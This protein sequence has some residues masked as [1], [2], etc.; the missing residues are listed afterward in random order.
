MVAVEK[1][2]DH[3]LEPRADLHRFGQRLGPDRHRAAFRAGRDFGD[4]FRPVFFAGD[5]ARADDERRIRARFAFAFKS[6]AQVF[7][8]GDA[9][10]GL[11]SVTPFVCERHRL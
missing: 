7:G 2:A 4:F 1:K 9:N 6:D 10:A 5:D 8:D 3:L 11:A